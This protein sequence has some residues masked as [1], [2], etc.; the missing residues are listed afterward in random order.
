M[1]SPPGHFSNCNIKKATKGIEDSINEDG[2]KYAKRADILD[3]I[4]GTN[5]CFVTLKGHKETFANYSTTS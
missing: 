5:N 2:I 4:D 1:Q 3:R